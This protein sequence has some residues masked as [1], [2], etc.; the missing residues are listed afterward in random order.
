MTARLEFC[1]PP[2][3]SKRLKQKNW[4]TVTRLVSGP[5][6]WYTRTGKVPIPHKWVGVNKGDGVNEKKIEI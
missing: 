3:W 6:K 4:D 1:C 5:S 2:R